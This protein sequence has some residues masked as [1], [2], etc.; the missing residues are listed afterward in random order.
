MVI[1]GV[2]HVIVSISLTLVYWLVTYDLH[3]ALDH[4]VHNAFAIIPVH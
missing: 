4:C 3:M 1:L 2:A